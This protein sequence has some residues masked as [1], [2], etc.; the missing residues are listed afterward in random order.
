MAMKETLL[1]IGLSVGGSIVST[2]YQWG[3]LSDRVSNN[4]VTIAAQQVKIDA[5]AADKVTQAAHNAKVEQSLDDIK[6]RLTRI[7]SKL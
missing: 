6:E 7:E 1:A 2:S 4:S 5:I 3:I